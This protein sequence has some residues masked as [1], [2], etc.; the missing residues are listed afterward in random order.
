MPRLSILAVLTLVAAPCLAETVSVRN[1][2]LCCASCSAGAK[3]ALSDV[4]GVSG[5][6]CD[7]NAK[8]IAF[9]AKDA[10]AAKKGVEA[11]ADGGF[12]GAAVYG[13]EKL[14]YPSPKI[15]KGQKSNSFLLTGLH[16]CC[17]ACVTAS[18]KALTSVKGVTVIDIDR[19]EET[20]QVNGDGVLVQD[21]IDALNKA[22]FYSKLAS[23]KKSAKK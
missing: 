8:V 14:P 13:K 17:G 7:L 1:T 3:A 21:A 19:N 5:V 18:Q 4:E 6:N 15:K 10:K 2:H 12:F 11:L 22:G 23:P 20:I 9:E 16:L